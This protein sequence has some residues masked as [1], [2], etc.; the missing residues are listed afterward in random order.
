MNK[1]SINDVVKAC[2]DHGPVGDLKQVIPP[3][4]IADG[5]DRIVEMF[6]SIGFFQ[7]VIAVDMSSGTKL[8]HKRK[9]GNISGI[10]V[11]F[12]DSFQ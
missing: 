12:F 5:A 4:E 10:A 11:I 8:G 2:A 3:V 1:I 9:K 7:G 6:I